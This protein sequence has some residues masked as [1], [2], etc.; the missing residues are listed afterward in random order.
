MSTEELFLPLGQVDLLKFLD[1]TSGVIQIELID[2]GMIRPITGTY[3]YKERDGRLLIAPVVSRGEAQRI[4]M[5]SKLPLTPRFVAF[6]GLY[7]GDGNKTNDIGFAQNEL[8]L[9]T[10]I[11]FGL[12]FL[13]G[14][15]FPVEMTL[16]EDE[17][18]FQGAAAEAKLRELERAAFTRGV[19]SEDIT[20]RYLHER[21]MNERLTGDAF[22]T[23]IDHVRYV[24]SAKKGARS[25]GQSSFEII[26][27][28]K[29]SRRFLPLFLA[30]LKE[31]IRTIEGNIKNSPKGVQW[32]GPPWTHA[33]QA[34]AVRGYIESGSCFYQSSRGQQRYS[35]VSE[36]S[37]TIEIKKARGS[38]FHV[39]K[40]IPISPL[41]CLMF[42]IYL[43]EG[44]TSKSKFFTF[45]KQP[46][47][48][49]IGFN[50]S[51][52]VSLSIFLRGL[53]LFYPN[54]NDVVEQ[55]LVKIG[56]KYFP[57][58][59][60]AAEKQGAPVVRGGS[61]GQGIARSPEVTEEYRSWA[62]AHFD[63]VDLVATK[64]S[65]IEF[66]GA[67]IARVDV[68]CKAQSAPLLFSL[69]VDLLFEPGELELFLVEG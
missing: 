49:A 30:V 20:R 69:V 2:A 36:G 11:D 16:L 39:R 61:K 42:G 68:R 9:Q 4:E 8:G 34:L 45:R 25:E 13:F 3:E 19:L 48:L 7:D 10:F 28:R 63:A 58:T 66:T 5:P 37:E 41:L 23:P 21:M 59:H 55:W 6:L 65:H 35:V 57:E 52:N 60:A 33:T 43:A 22:A 54:L 47:D 46:E 31:V 15:V 24:I 26:K 40:E 1:A 67:G 53:S 44:T 50:S 32:N 18:A 27:N 51:E 14:D 12:D 38:S 29:G 62:M 17:K 64:F 56:T